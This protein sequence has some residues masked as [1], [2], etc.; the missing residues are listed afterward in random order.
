MKKKPIFSEMRRTPYDYW[1]YGG[2]RCAG[3]NAAKT[4]V[5][6]TRRSNENTIGIHCRWM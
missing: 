3:E 4:F 2:K 5:Y 6:Q 1:K